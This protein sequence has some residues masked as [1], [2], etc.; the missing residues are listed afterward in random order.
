MKKQVR[1]YIETSGCAINRFYS[2][3][4]AG[5]L[6]DKCFT[7]VDRPDHADI[8]VLNACVIKKPTEDRMIARAKSLYKLNAHLIISG[9]L[10]EM[11][12]SRLRKMFP[13]ASVIGI[14]NIARIPEL[15]EK[16]EPKEPILLINEPEPYPDMLV[17]PRILEKPY[18]AVVPIAK[19]CLGSCTYCI[20]KLIWGHLKSYPRE[21]IIEEIKQLVNKGIK[22]IRLSGQD[23]GPYGWDL[24]YTL[25]DL[26]AD[27]SNIPGDFM[28]RIGM[29]SPDTL[30]RIID[31]LLDIMVSEKR[32][33][34]YIHI[35][36]QS[37]SN[38]ILKLMQRKYR[39]EDF[40]ELVKTIRSRLGET[41]TIATDI[42]SSFP[43]ESEEDHNA[44][45]ELLK[46]VKPDIVNLSRYG[47]R[48]GVPS[49]K[50]YPKVHSGVSKR[51][52]REIYNVIRKISL[53]KNR[54]YVGEKLD[55]LLLDKENS[56][57]LGRTINYRIVAIPEN[58]TL[59]LGKWVKV[60]INDATWKVLYG[61]ARTS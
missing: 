17:K 52:T 1:V 38:R 28:I 4:L 21:K 43:T 61:A 2:E 51:R 10:A 60:E 31:D 47:D 22:E 5:L 36:V 53:E 46:R 3:V 59:Q 11:L 37:G 29:A 34:R 58:S 45:I 42:I 7:L 13:K 57:L 14:H 20:D 9:C 25:A 19:G 54:R 44:T 15:I 33:Y 40:E 55:V 8:I 30:M 39:A 56:R 12:S 27:I 6:R 41:V 23:T 50:I 35:P 16:I 26:L 48:P 32:I 49:S 24:G 18:I